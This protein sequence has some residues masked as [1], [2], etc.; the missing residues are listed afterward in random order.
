PNTGESLAA[1][2]AIVPAV[3]TGGAEPFFPTG[4]VASRGASGGV[5]GV[6]EYFLPGTGARPCPRAGGFPRPGQGAGAA[7]GGPPPAAPTPAMRFGMGDRS[8]C[9]QCQQRT[10]HDMFQLEHVPFLHI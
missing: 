8:A 5:P 4:V 6:V 1:V 7:G 2:T 9:D 3:T 10:C